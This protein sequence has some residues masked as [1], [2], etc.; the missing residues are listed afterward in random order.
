MENKKKLKDLN[1]E[2]LSKEN[3]KLL[4]EVELLK[5][6]LIFRLSRTKF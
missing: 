1:K 6:N 4:K 3:Q 5:N 2:S